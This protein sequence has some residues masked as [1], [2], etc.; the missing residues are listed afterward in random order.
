MLLKTFLEYLQI[1]K[2]YSEHTVTAYRRDLSDFKAWLA[3]FAGI[4]LFDEGQ[5]GLITH[6]MVRMWMGF[7][8]EKRLSKRSVARKVASVSTYYKFLQRT[9]TVESNPVARVKVPKYEKKLPAFLKEDST[10][11]LFGQ[12]DTPETFEDF[13]NQC[14]M[15]VLY[16]CGLRSSELIGLKFRDIDFGNRTLKVL[17]KG[18]KE[19]IT[20]FGDA[21]YNAMK[22]YM[23]ACEEQG[24]NYTGVFFVKK[25]GKP[26]YSKLLYRMVNTTLARASSISKKSPHVLRH[27]FATHLLDRGADLNAIKE[28]LGHNSLAATEVY[29]HNTITKLKK[30]HESAHPRERD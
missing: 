15:E 2:N 12:F 5:V 9:G 6:K 30:I 25:D 18:N 24:L 14:M 13:R 10:Q 28:L 29:T 27:S 22:A 20:P 1:E 19:R 16:G 4:E 21:V 8:L 3:E 17:G 7:L 26:V 23:D 11:R